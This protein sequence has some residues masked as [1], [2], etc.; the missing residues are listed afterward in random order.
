MPEHGSEQPAEAYHVS[1]F[2]YQYAGP[3]ATT[4]TSALKLN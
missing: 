4:K 1:I 3:V 2:A